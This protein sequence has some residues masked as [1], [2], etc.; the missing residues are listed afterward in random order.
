MG[1]GL[2]D[3]LSSLLGPSHGPLLHLYAGSLA[4][5]VVEG[6][7][8]TTEAR[9]PGPICGFQLA[10]PYFNSAANLSR[11]MGGTGWHALPSLLMLHIPPLK[12]DQDLHQEE[13][14]NCLSIGHWLQ[15]NLFVEIL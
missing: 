6:E 11:Q 10:G 3:D 4:Q 7:E 14:G 5:E 9:L 12:G 8:P 2:S 1:R 15:W 13:Q